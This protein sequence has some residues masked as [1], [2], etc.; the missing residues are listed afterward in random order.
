MSSK[1][2][3]SFV[4]AGGLAVA[5]GAGFLVGGL[6]LGA[7][8][9]FVA[10]GQLALSHLAFFEERKRRLPRAVGPLPWV[11]LAMSYLLVA[12]ALGL[13]LLKT[14]S[15]DR[16]DTIA[17]AGQAPG[18]ETDGQNIPE[19]LGSN[20]ASGGERARLGNVGRGEGD[21]ATKGGANEDNQNAM[22]EAQVF[23]PDIAGSVAGTGE[24]TNVSAQE[25][26]DQVEPG[27]ADL[28][29][30]DAVDELL[31]RVGEDD[32][33]V[34]VGNPDAELVFEEDDNSLAF[35]VTVFQGDKG[36]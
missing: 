21:D 8:L 9:L 3:A 20:I 25:I 13:F 27:D 23:N 18:D 31:A 35:D 30:A 36:S 1:L 32:E 26:P 16:Q 6:I 7:A 15:D 14:L 19:S 10:L 17:K 12:M 34:E 28:G 5:M 22:R 29:K 24:L 4:L 2:I 33:N 11:N